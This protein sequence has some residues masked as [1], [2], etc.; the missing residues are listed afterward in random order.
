MALRNCCSTCQIHRFD[1][2]RTYNLKKCTKPMP[3]G[4]KLVV[5]A[6][7]DNSLLNLNNPDSTATVGWGEQTFNEMF[8]AS[9]R[10]T[11]PDAKLPAAKTTEKMTSELKD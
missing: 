3:K 1:W 5:E 9:F 2:Q 8:F 10:Y 4:T 7:W 6:A 11:C